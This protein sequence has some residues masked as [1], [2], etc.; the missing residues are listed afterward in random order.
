MKTQLL[1]IEK[2]F[3]AN[4]HKKRSMQS[5]GNGSG[6]PWQFSQRAERSWL[7]PSQGG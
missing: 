1:L 4:F 5:A 6:F 2:I 7:N 3:T